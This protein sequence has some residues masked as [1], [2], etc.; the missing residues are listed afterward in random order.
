MMK[1]RVSADEAGVDFESALAVFDVEFCGTLN[2]GKACEFV[3]S[4]E[5]FA[6]I[7]AKNAKDSLFS[8]CR[9]IVDRDDWKDNDIFPS[10]EFFAWNKDNYGPIYLP[11]AGDTIN[12]APRTAPMYKNIITIFEGNDYQSDIYHVRVNQREVN[13]YVT[14]KN[15]YFLLNDDRTKKFDSRSFGP[16]PTE[17][18][19]GKISND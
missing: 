2:D 13:E 8:A 6:Q 16:I 4:R 14:Q 19:I 11:L 3:C 12:L 1:F 10:S 5:T 17:Y 18:I 9:M 15:Y 7:E